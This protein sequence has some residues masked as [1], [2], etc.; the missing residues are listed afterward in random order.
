VVFVSKQ[1]RLLLEYAQLKEELGL[2]GEKLLKFFIPGFSPSLEQQL[3]VVFYS[4][5]TKFYA[6]INYG[7]QKRFYK[8]K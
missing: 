6:K 2:I 4:L 5:F 8:N 3:S 1:F 7:F